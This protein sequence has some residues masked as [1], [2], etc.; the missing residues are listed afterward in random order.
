MDDDASIEYPCVFQ[1]PYCDAVSPTVYH[2]H[3]SSLGCTACKAM[4]VKVDW[5][6]RGRGP[7]PVPAAPPPDGFI[8]HRPSGKRTA[9][10][11]RA[12]ARATDPS[13]SHAAAAKIV[14]LTNRQAVVLSILRYQLDGEAT[15][16]ELCEQYQSLAT[17]YD[18]ESAL[19][20]LP[21]QSRS[22]IRTRRRELVDRGLVLDT[23]RKRTLP[24]GNKG[25]VWATT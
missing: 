9:P 3:W 15:D 12:R 18:V 5:I 2:G 10:Q 7:L 4:I 11:E 8:I 6:H 14:D 20:S 21:P 1:C 24:S 17:E 19:G 22:G 25:I 23:G 13:T 16:E